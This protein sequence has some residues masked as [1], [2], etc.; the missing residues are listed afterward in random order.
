MANVTFDGDFCSAGEWDD[1]KSKL[2]LVFPFAA[3]TFAA[4]NQKSP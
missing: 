1:T 2:F 3:L 4:E